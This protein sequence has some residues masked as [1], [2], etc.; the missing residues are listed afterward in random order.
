VVDSSKL[1]VLKAQLLADDCK[2]PEDPTEVGR[3]LG[4]V[5]ANKKS[6]FNAQILSHLLKGL[7]LII[8]ES[9]CQKTFRTAAMEFR[10]NCSEDSLMMSME[11]QQNINSVDEWHALSNEL[12]R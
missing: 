3:L 6:M 5:L 12:S 1:I 7:E 4:F 11:T 9:E 10:N 2:D 8:P